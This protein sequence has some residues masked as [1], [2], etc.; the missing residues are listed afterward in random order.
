MVEWG[1]WCESLPLSFSQARDIGC[2][3]VPPPVAESAEEEM[4]DLTGESDLSTVSTLSKASSDS[5][6]LTDIDGQWIIGTGD[7]RDLATN[8]PKTPNHNTLSSKTK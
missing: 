8:R 2:P 1:Q 5:S 3:S 7:C 6:K 4:L